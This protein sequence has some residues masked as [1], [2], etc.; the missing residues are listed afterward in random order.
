MNRPG[1]RNLWTE[2]SPRPGRTSLPHTLGGCE[3]SAT[4]RTTRT[5]DF[6]QAAWPAVQA[7]IFGSPTP[8]IYDLGPGLPVRRGRLQKYVVT[9]ASPKGHCSHH[10]FLQVAPA[11]CPAQQVNAGTRDVVELVRLVNYLSD[12]GLPTAATAA[13]LLLPL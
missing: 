9:A 12:L 1:R 7:H 10:I 13:A 8:N 6:E 2:I 5:N 4:K 3:V 11:G